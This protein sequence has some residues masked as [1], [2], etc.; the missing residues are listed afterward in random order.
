MKIVGIETATAVC[1]AAVVADGRVL[2]EQT[3][4][5]PRLHAE[6]LM[7]LIDDVLR[8]SQCAPKELDAVAISI[9][10]GSFTGLRIGL[11]VAKGLCFA[12]ERPLVAVPTLDALAHR[13]AAAGVVAT[14]FLCAALDARR[15]EVYC[16]LFR[17]N[18]HLARREGDVRDMTLEELSEAIAGKEVTFSGNARTKLASH[19]G[20]AAR[21][22]PDEYAACRASA[23][24]LLGEQ[25]A[26]RGEFADL[27]TIE[28]AYV[29]EFFTMRRH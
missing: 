16:A 14:P 13:A 28:P 26:L 12:L 3:R 23:V 10:P 17:V 21:F 5:E 22:V 29:K 7:G 27:R 4:E 2:A 8:D 20:S 11:S 19:F 24:A 25:M 1:G 15:N 18:G 6:A 9:G